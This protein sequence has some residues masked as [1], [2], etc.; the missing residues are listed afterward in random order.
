[1]SSQS[2]NSIRI[3]GSTQKIIESV[4][5]LATIRLSIILQG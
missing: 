4:L 3:A 1:M 5:H 2:S